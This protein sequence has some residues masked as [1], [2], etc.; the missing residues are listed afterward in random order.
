VERIDRYTLEAKIGEG[1][2]GSVYRGRHE[3]LGRQVAV[4][5]L[6]VRRGVERF[7]RE[8]Q[9]LAKLDHPNVVRVHD[10]GVTDDGRAFL[11]LDLLE[12]ITLAEHLESGA[13]PLGEAVWILEQVLQALACAH[14][15]GVVH[16]DLKPR[17]SSSRARRLGRTS[18]PS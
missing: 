4:K 5:V 13:I 11:V 1:G 17:T 18:G 3:V 2:F 7:L 14:E 15:Q 10:S 6:H 9:V 16:R 12:G 8:A